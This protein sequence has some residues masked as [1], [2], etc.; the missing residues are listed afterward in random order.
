MYGRLG[1]SLLLG[2]LGSGISSQA[3]AQ[4]RPD[5]LPPPDVIPGSELSMEERIERAR[6]MMRKV[7]E[8]VEQDIETAQQPALAKLGR[9]ESGPISPD[10]LVVEVFVS[11][12]MTDATIQNL[13][14]IQALDSK[15]G[16][17]VEHRD[18]IVMG[19]ELPAAPSLSPGGACLED[20]RAQ[21]DY[22]GELA[23]A[24]GVTELPYFAAHYG[25]ETT[26]GPLDE[27]HYLI[28]KLIRQFGL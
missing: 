11:P 5:G 13:C 10:R 25:G 6:Q 26:H 23:R 7:S 12:A 17:R 19:G 1:L 4:K 28:T 27:Q 3:V 24:R 14:A 18:Y 16:V 21:T 22:G 2:L 15:V 9:A 20:W 8:S